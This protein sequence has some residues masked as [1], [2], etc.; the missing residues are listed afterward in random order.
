[1][2]QGVPKARG[3][4]H[5]GHQELPAQGRILRNGQ[6]GVGFSYLI[7]HKFCVN[8]TQVERC[9][10]RFEIFSL[11]SIYWAYYQILGRG[12]GGFASIPLPPEYAPDASIL[13]LI[14]CWTRI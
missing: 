14:L 8:T 9:I 2:I 1:M 3:Y 7:I 4:V 10:Y 13:G 5:Q 6:V 11:H 12:G